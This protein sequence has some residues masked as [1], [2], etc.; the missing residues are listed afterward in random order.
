MIIELS[1]QLLCILFA[2]FSGRH[3]VPAI[4]NFRRFGSADSEQKRFHN[5]N[6]F[7]KGIVAAQAAAIL[8]MNDCNWK[9]TALIVTACLFWMWLFFDVTINLL[10]AGP[11]KWDYLGGKNVIDIWLREHGGKYAGK[12]KAICCVVIA[13][14]LNFLTQIIK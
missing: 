11:F 2:H 14:G 9:E 10:R 4:N 7:M 1:I 6:T 13:I 8:L 3:D 12:I 5:A